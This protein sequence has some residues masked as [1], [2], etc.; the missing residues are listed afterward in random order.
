MAGEHARPRVL[1][2]RFHEE[3]GSPRRARRRQLARRLARSRNGGAGHVAHEVA[4]ADRSGR[5]LGVRPVPERHLPVVPGRSDAQP[6]FRRVDRRADARA[7]DDAGA[8]GRVPQE[9]SYRR[10]ARLGATHARPLPA[11]M[12]APRRRSGEDRVGRERPHP[13]GRVCA[14]APEAHAGRECRDRAALRP[15]PAG[16]KARR[17]LR[18]R[19]PIRG[20]DGP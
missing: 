20:R 9:P 16:G 14:R 1:L 13:A 12:A 6:V 8:A 2:P 19:L 4:P 3:A 7:A 18:D 17:V 10:A 11:Q 15:S 5:N